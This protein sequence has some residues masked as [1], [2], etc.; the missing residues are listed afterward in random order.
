MVLGE[1]RN[2]LRVENSFLKL[3]CFWAI[4]AAFIDDG[5][6]PVSHDFIRNFKVF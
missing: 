2:F 4:A 6:E 1:R 5:C 3:H